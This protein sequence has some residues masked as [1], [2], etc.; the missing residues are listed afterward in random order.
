MM[1]R[2]TVIVRLTL[3]NNMLLIFAKFTAVIINTI[4]TVPLASHTTFHVEAI[5]PNG[6]LSGGT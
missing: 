2:T 4:I 6:V 5:Q 3:E 1:P